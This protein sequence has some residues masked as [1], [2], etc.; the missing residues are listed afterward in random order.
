LEQIFGLWRLPDA[1]EQISRVTKV[2]T[3]NPRPLTDEEQIYPQEGI[4]GL[5]TE[6]TRE[7][8]CPLAFLW[9][10]GVA[11][12]AAA[13]RYN[14]FID[15][16]TE[17]LRMHQF[18]IFVGEKGT[19]KS[20]G[21][22]AATEI[23]H[24]LNCLVRPTLQGG[25]PVSWE[26]GHPPVNLR[27]A[28]PFEVRFLPQ[29]TNQMVLVS[30]LADRTWATAQVIPAQERTTE[31]PYPDITSDNSGFLALDEL[32]LLFGRENWAVGQTITFM[33]TIYAD[34]PYIYETKRS[35]RI[36]LSRPA[37]TL[38]GCCPPDLMQSA[39][40]P[41]L[42]Q[43]GLMDRTIV[44]YREP[45][46]GSSGNYPTPRPRDPLQAVQIAELL[47]PLTARWRP[48][49]ILATEE[50]T[51]WY[52]AW[53][54]AQHASLDPREYSIPRLANHVWKLAATLSIS[55]GSLP[56]IHPRHF[57]Q[58]ALVLS[59]E[60]AWYRKLLGYMEQAPEAA[61]MNRLERTLYVNGAVAPAR[62][63]R[64]RLFDAVRGVRGLSPP[65]VRAVPLLESLEASGRIKTLALRNGQS[66]KLTTWYQ[67]MPEAAEQ[68][69]RPD[70]PSALPESIV[71]GQ[72]G[73]P[74]LPETASRE[75]G[76]EHTVP[77]PEPEPTPASSPPR[78]LPQRASRPVLRS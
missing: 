44:I 2:V 20:T 60:M 6:W 8:D 31:T 58:A 26:P 42:F 77:E 15:R 4:L 18:L 59:H 41:L 56:W 9:W 43:G 78:R 1:F 40:H 39:V 33:N 75:S 30:A 5:F 17:P 22:H 25:I 37:L 53:Y 46:V 14:F 66:G 13:C 48:E 76:A 65:T 23:L 72:P 19:L 11:T 52:E 61:L 47:R 45:L 67:L 63:M 70:I 27:I 32:A 3:F 36:V 73:D 57:Q 68:F 69:K 7:S 24:H 74:R 21:L 35:G 51:T 38:L 10:S 71:P 64:S 34:K 54:H 49:E 29:D 12:I 55:D 28:H 50:A 62:M 16:G